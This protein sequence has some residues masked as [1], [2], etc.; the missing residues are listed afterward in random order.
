M[1]LNLNL[2]SR[3]IIL[4]KIIKF[5]VAFGVCKN[6]CNY[7]FYVH[8][9]CSDYPEKIPVKNYQ[10]DLCK[11]SDELNDAF[12]GCTVVV[13]CAGKPF[14]YLQAEKDLTEQYQCDNF[15]SLF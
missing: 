8:L 14:E 4:T 13:F 15:S 12:N 5:L 1:F 9:I 6:F 7:K 3:A 10:C 11:E 2:M